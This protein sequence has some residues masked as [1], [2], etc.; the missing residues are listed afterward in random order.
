MAKGGKSFIDELNAKGSDQPNAKGPDQ[1]DAKGP[2]QPDAKGPDVGGGHTGI[3]GGIGTVAGVKGEAIGGKTG[4]ID[5]GAPCISLDQAFTVIESHL[6]NKGAFTYTQM[7]MGIK[8]SLSC[9]PS[10]E[11]QWFKDIAEMNL[12]PLWMVLWAQYRRCQE[13]GVA[14]SLLLDPGWGEQEVK[15]LEERECD[16]CHEKFMPTDSG[17]KFDKNICG[18]E[19]AIAEKRK[20]V[21]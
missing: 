20:K 11:Q 15:Q 14:A 18:A 10:P 13:N 16:Y 1:P 4:A 7:D 5:G 21:A 19:F 8:L 17:Q 6:K 12:V 9:I 2:D 3:S